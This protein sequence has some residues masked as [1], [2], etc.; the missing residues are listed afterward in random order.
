VTQRKQR[1]EFATLRPGE[2]RSLARFE[3][4]LGV[5]LL[6]CALSC[7]SSK[8]ASRS[9]IAGTAGPIT[10]SSYAPEAAEQCR[11]LGRQVCRYW[12]DPSRSVSGQ[13]AESVQ[14]TAA[15]AGANYIHVDEPSST[16]LHYD[17]DLPTAIFY[18][19]TSLIAN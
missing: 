8:L 15:N 4:L 16:D 12:D 5:C 19:C 13:C 11:E 17:T 14:V 9:Q 6:A 3:L 18:R 2:A 7:T 1:A 10:A